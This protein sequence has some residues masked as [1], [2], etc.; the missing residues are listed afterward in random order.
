MGWNIERR[1][2][3]LIFMGFLASAAVA[4]AAAYIILARMIVDAG[5]GD[6]GPIAVIAGGALVG[7]LTAYIIHE[8]GNVLPGVMSRLH[9]G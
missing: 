2:T 6:A 8:V 1:V 9:R 5:A 7:A 4:M 3:G